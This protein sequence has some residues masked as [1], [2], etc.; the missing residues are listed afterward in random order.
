MPVRVACVNLV[1]GTCG[2]L[3]RRGCVWASGPARGPCVSLVWGVP[4][5][6]GGTVTTL[7]LYGQIVRPKKH[8]LAPNFVC[9]R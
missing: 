5:V 3:V 4:L 1:G 9:G 7:P 6:Q 8:Y 2:P